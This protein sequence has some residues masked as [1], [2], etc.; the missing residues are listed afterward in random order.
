MLPVTGT[1]NLFKVSLTTTSKFSIPAG[2]FIS[3]A[4]TSVKLPAPLM[5]T[6]RLPV[7]FVAKLDLSTQER[8]KKS[9]TAPLYKTAESVGG[10]AFTKI[11]TGLLNKV[12]FSF[13]MASCGKS[14]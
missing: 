13:C 2:H 6:C 3:G 8:I 10:K 14:R 9:P 4:F 5:F 7:S 1:T 12:T 11:L